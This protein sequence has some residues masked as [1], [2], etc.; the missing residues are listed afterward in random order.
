MKENF[1]GKLTCPFENGK[2]N[3]TT[4]RKLKNSNFI[5]ESKITELNQIKN[6]KQ[7][8]RSDAVGKLYFTLEINE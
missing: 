2:R 3:L 8:D 6:L 1:E 4:F 5:L 7:L